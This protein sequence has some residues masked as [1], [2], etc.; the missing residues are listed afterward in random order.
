[1]VDS[2][3]ITFE[4]TK[5]QESPLENNTNTDLLQTSTF[6]DPSQPSFSLIH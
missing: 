1:M 3:D 5:T 2:E 4:K 6:N